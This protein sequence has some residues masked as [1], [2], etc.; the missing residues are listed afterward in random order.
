MTILQVELKTPKTAPKASRQQLLSHSIAA[1]TALAKL[2]TN[3]APLMTE[4][5]TIHVCSFL[6]PR[7]RRTLLANDIQSRKE[8]SMSLSG[9]HQSSKP[10]APQL[11]TLLMLTPGIQTDEIECHGT[12]H[13][14]HMH[15]WL[16]SP[17]A[18][19]A[20]Q[21]TYLLRNTGFNATAQAIV[22]LIGFI[23]GLRSI[24][25]QQLRTL[26][27][28]HGQFAPLCERA[29][30]LRSHRAVLTGCSCKEHVDASRL[31]ACTGH[32]PRLA[33]VSLRTAHRLLLP[34]HLKLLERVASGSPRL[35]AL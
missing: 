4:I 23:A 16:S 29:A 34:V 24:L 3:N 7:C 12:D 15:G 18:L 28:R 8:S 11:A 9:S 14:L 13:L 5:V 17:A 31:L 22:A 6:T 1:L 27:R 10:T 2:R 30:T 26:A 35:P 25:R 20:S 21:P 32:L 19:S 33:L